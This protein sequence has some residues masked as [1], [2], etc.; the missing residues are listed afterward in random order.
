MFTSKRKQPVKT[1]KTTSAGIPLVGSCGIQRCLLKQ[2]P[3]LDLLRVISRRVSGWWN[4]AGAWLF[5]KSRVVCCDIAQTKDKELRV[6]ETA[7]CLREQRSWNRA[8][9][10]SHAVKT[11]SLP[12]CAALIETLDISP[13]GRFLV[14]ASLN[15]KDTDRCQWALIAVKAWHLVDATTWIK[16]F[17][18][19][20]RSNRTI[21]LESAIQIVE[22]GAWRT[23]ACGFY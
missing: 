22:D 18:K 21:A 6:R 9:R 16:T 4:G 12:Y 8:E 5:I 1:H 11:S 13:V 23:S 10:K 20:V 7:S 19:Q 17:E 14:M 15:K 3:D 2:I